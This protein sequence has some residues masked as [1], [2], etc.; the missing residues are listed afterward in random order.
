LI[1]TKSYIEIEK[2]N[3]YCVIMRI[4]HFG[5]NFFWKSET[6][7]NNGSKRIQYDPMVAYYGKSNSD[8]GEFFAL[9]IV[10]TIRKCSH[11]ELKIAY[12]PGFESCNFEI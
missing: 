11:N 8:E 12:T 5:S 1:S 9:E 10:M 3:D 2:I 4:K 7:T 6:I